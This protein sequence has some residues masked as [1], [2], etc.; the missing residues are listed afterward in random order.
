MMSATRTGT[1]ATSATFSGTERGTDAT[2]ATFPGTERGTEQRIA[3]DL[4]AFGWGT[5][6]AS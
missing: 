3:N 1:D 5:E 6:V 4:A 2:S